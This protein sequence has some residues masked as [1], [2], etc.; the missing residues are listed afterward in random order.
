MGA[1]RASSCLL[2]LL[3]GLP[4]ALMWLIDIAEGLQHLH[5]QDP[6]LIHRDIKL[7]NILLHDCHEQERMVARITDLGLHVVLKQQRRSLR[8]STRS[9]LQAGLPAL[10]R[11]QPQ[12]SR[13]ALRPHSQPASAQVSRPASPGLPDAST[14]FEPARA[15]PR[16][17]IANV[18]SGPEG[19][20]KEVDGLA[21]VCKPHDQ[22]SRAVLNTVSQRSSVP[23]RQHSFILDAPALQ[24]IFLTKGDHPSAAS[25]STFS[26]AKLMMTSKLSSKTSMN[27]VQGASGTSS[28]NPDYSRQASSLLHTSLPDCSAV[29]EASMDKPAPD[30][31]ASSPLNSTGP[32][33]IPSKAALNSTDLQQ[34]GDGLWDDDSAWPAMLASIVTQ[35]QSQKDWQWVFSLTGQTGSAVYMA[36]EVHSGE[37][38]N[39]SA[40]VHSFGILAYELLARS[41]LVFSHIGTAA[42]PGV[43]TAERFAECIAD[44]YRPARPDCIADAAVWSLIEDCWH[45]DPN[46]RPSMAALLPR[47]QQALQARLAAGDQLLQV[48]GMQAGCTA[49][50]SIM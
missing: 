16:L 12:R 40:D 11:L 24:H 42:L 22:D 38:Y 19:A 9:L 1:A 13:L 8:V 47:L 20:P 4:Q 32:V 34:L 44:G 31:G 46:T 27:E 33:K 37:P 39:T 45:P 15:S 30:S 41:M 28:T 26:I 17:R 7:D 6:P 2:C 49:D 21:R 5:G 48:R 36:P 29:A 23:S 3:V 25:E 43:T 10:P 35:P 14:T 50:C 18:N